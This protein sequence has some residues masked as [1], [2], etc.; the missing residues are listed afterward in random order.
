MWDFEERRFEAP[1]RRCGKR[2][3]QPEQLTLAA[4][5]RRNMFQGAELIAR[6]A[7]WRKRV[8]GPLP[9]G[10]SRNE[11]ICTSFGDARN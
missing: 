4:I 6:M 7:L 11:W 3:A 1:W 5:E 10:F 2:V 8:A 9:D